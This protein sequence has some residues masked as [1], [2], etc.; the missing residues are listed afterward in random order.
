M[1]VAVR[2]L[3]EDITRSSQHSDI[4]TNFRGYRAENCQG[5]V[6]LEKSDLSSKYAWLKEK[7]VCPASGRPLEFTASGCRS[8]GGDHEYSF[9][10]DVLDLRKAPERLQIDL[11]WYEPWNDLDSLRISPPDS[12]QSRELPYHLDDHLAAVP[13]EQGDGRWLLEIGCGA[14]QCETWFQK[15]GFQYVGTDVDV[16]GPGPHLLADAHNLPFADNSFDFYLSTAVY[17]HLVSPLTAALEGYRVLRKGGIFFGSAAFVYGFHDRAS[18]HHM[19]HGGLLYTL[20]A[21][22]FVVERMWPDWPYTASIAEMGFR[23]RQGALWR[24]ATQAFLNGAEWSFTSVSAL[25]RRLFKK[26]PLNM[27]ERALHMAGSVSFVARKDR[28]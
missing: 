24:L 14:R 3:Y 11:P 2:G 16:R 23:G 28:D 6:V 9:M 26:A 22:G 18:F 4:P 21:A 8:V 12:L 19:S 13:G 10:G 25:A 15:R 7:L 1:P 20:R 27:A 17:E 5:F